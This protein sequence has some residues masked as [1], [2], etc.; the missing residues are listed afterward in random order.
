MASNHIASDNTLQIHAKK[1]P[2]IDTDLS[3][4]DTQP[5]ISK[6]KKHLMEA[7]AWLII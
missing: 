3:Q 7:H 6:Q 1:L 2:Q 5:C 4:F